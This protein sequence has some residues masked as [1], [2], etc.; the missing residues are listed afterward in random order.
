MI[1]ADQVRAAI[2]VMP[3]KFTSLDILAAFPLLKMKS[4]SA[5]LRD[6]ELR[7]EIECYE[8]RKTYKT[9]PIKVYQKCVVKK[10]VACI[11]IPIETRSPVRGCMLRIVKHC[12]D[13][14][15]WQE[16]IHPC[17]DPQP[18]YPSLTELLVA[19]RSTHTHTSLRK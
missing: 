2:K 19:M 17:Y 3:E 11:D 6:L 12:D 8:F 10:P 1:G 9:K 5:R 7:G 13:T 18:P 16:R 15:S 14:D 4:V